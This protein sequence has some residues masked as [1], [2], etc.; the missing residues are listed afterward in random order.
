MRALGYRL[1]HHDPLLYNPDNY[2]G[3]AYNMF[4]GIVS[5]NIVAWPEER[6]VTF[7]LNDVHLR[8]CDD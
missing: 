3:F 8:H 5:P 6:E 1:W 2:A 4:P 7:N